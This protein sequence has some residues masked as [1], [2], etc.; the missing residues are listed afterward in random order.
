MD[1]LMNLIK[2][3]PNPILG[4]PSIVPIIPRKIIKPIKQIPDIQK[5]I[6]IFT[7]LPL[8]YLLTIKIKGLD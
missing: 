3:R 8:K 7:T 4:R 6:F 1:M 5:L 2:K